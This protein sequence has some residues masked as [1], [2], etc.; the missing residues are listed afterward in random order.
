MKTLVFIVCVLAVMGMVYSFD[1]E[2]LEKFRQDFMECK[3]ESSELSVRFHFQ[4]IKCAM[5]KD[6]KI[7][8]ENGEYIKE[9][10]LQKL[11]D[12]ISDPNMLNLARLILT[13]CYDD[14][15]QSGATGNDQTMKIIMCGLSAA[16]SIEDS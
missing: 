13:K 12:L 1:I 3:E 7:L 4:A 2:Q 9:L 15:V 14:V 16:S 6:D 11:D 10:A 5:L 8:N